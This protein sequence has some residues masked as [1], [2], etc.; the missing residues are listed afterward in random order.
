MGRQD[1][2][3]GWEGKGIVEALQALSG[4]REVPHHQAMVHDIDQVGLLRGRDLP[5]FPN[6]SPI[7]QRIFPFKLRPTLREPPFPRP[8]SGMTRSNPGTWH[9]PVRLDARLRRR[10]YAR[11]WESLVWVRQG[12]KGWVK[13]T[14]QGMREWEER[15]GASDDNGVLGQDEEKRNEEEDTVAEVKRKRREKKKSRGRVETQIAVLKSV[16]RWSVG[17]DE[18]RKWLE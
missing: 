6:L 14:H 15:G 12:D 18:D 17:S 2:A 11:F 10:V 3:T 7:L 8:P 4:L 9:H 13:C 5:T 1:P 16:S